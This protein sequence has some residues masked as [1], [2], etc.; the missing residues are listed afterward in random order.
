MATISDPTKYP[1][2]TLPDNSFSPFS[3]IFVNT[4]FVSESIYLTVVLNLVTGFPG[5]DLGT[6]KDPDVPNIPA[7]TTFSE[8]I[9]AADLANPS[10]LLQ[11][12]VY[13]PPN[14]TSG[15]S[16]EVRATIYVSPGPYFFPGYPYP[17]ID[18]AS[19]IDTVTA[20]RITGTT[21]NQ[22]ASTFINPFGA[23]TIIDN[24]FKQTAQDI[25]T[26]TI[27]DDDG[28]PTDNLGGLRGAGF[29]GQTGVGTYTITATSPTTLTTELH[30]VSLLVPDVSGTQT[31]HLE[32]DVTDV[33]PNSA[34][35]PPSNASAAPP[36]DFNLTSKDTTTSVI[37]IGPLVTVSISGTPQEG[38]TL[39]AISNNANVVFHW[40]RSPD[41]K[42]WTDISGALGSTYMV[43]EA[44]ENDVIRALAFTSPSSSFPSDP[45]V[46][47]T[48]VPPKLTVTITG[49]TQEGS[50][51]TAS[52]TLTTDSD[53]STKDVTYQ[54]Q[55]S[56]DSGKTWSDI[57]GATGTTYKT[58]AADDNDLIRN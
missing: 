33:P 9:N 53:N 31:A 32:L 26:I 4:D 20:P 28:K 21:A 55:R 8:P 58:V 40:Q 51:L 2:Y 36:D 54:W 11:R 30:S 12:L 38:Q 18:T 34:S 57:G 19:L 23:V 56:A 1:W 45:T 52:P 41:G 5:N 15:Q 39:T 7:G 44:D 14:F 49:G 10:H 3:G 42:T 48:D 27:T 25:A 35:V 16:T 17:A 13:T 46:K 6:I 50:T 24:D 29:L 43:A 47:I 22:P 37:E